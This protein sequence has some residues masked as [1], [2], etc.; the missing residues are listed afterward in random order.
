MTTDNATRG[1]EEQAADDPAVQPIPPHLSDAESPTRRYVSLLRA[2]CAAGSEEAL[3]KA[4]LLSQEFISMGVSPDE[5]VAL[6]TD[7]VQEVVQ[8][9]DPRSLV[10]SQQFLLEVMIAFGVRY[11]EY[12]E[13][14]LAEARKSVE[15]EHE[16]ADEATKAEQ[17]RLELLAV[18]S[19]ELGQPLTVAR[20]NVAAIRRFLGENNRLSHDLSL[21]AIDAETAIERLLT[22][23]EELM[24]ASRN[25]RRDLELAPLNIENALTRALKW[26][27]SAA[28]E[29][30]IELKCT[31]GASKTRV[32]GDPDALQSIFGNLL[33]NAI[34]Y[35]APGGN[36]TVST[37]NED[38]SLLVS[39]ADTGIG[40]SPEAKARLFQRFYRAPEAK[41]LASWGLGLGLAIAN[42]L[43][44]ALD[45]SISAT[46]EPGKG[47]TFTVRFPCSA[48]EEDG[49][50]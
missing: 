31:F 4:S 48:H 25:E 45:A 47:A 27:E 33:S 44:G 10:A 36:V 37:Q 41:Q 12:A 24:A 46:S 1:A 49:N 39:I 28:Q 21:R 5:I 14:R 2:F 13:F 17:E 23:R 43:A 11:T 3:Y 34:R 18:I 7:A 22:L 19:H 29:K 8:A 26:A 16:R 38:T 32:V 30:K 6:H 42:E 35:T 20:G 40:L 9:F 50:D 15:Q